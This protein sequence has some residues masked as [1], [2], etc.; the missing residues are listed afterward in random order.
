VARNCDLLYDSKFGVPKSYGLLPIKITANIILP[1]FAHY[2]LC[3]TNIILPIKITNWEPTPQF[4]V[5]IEVQIT[6][7]CANV[8]QELLGIQPD[9]KVRMAWSDTPR[10]G[11]YK[12][13]QGIG[14]KAFLVG[15][16]KHGYWKWPFIVDLPIKNG[17]FP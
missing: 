9:E 7:P 11:I 14:S 17:D 5:D 12:T 4:E 10:H 6:P 15:G 13:L 1:I 16:F 8:G 3:S 2:G